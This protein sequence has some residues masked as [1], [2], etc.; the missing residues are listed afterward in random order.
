[1]GRQEPRRHGK[2]NSDWLVKNRSDGRKSNRMPV[3][4][5]KGDQLEKQGL[6]KTESIYEAA[7]KDSF[8]KQNL[9]VQQESVK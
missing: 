5:N 2:L 4:K 7:A 9:L 3:R 8:C 6:F 1:L